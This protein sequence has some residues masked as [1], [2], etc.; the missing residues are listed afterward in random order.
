MKSFLGDGLLTMHGQPWRRQ[1]HVIA[2]G[3]NAKQFSFK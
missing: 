3:T 1:R 2:E